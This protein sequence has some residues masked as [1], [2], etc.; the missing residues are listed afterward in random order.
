M[1]F[2]LVMTNMILRWKLSVLVTGSLETGTRDI[3]FP[4][5]I[6]KYVL[7]IRK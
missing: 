5:K 2:L 3:I 6:W 1:Q 7:K 4:K